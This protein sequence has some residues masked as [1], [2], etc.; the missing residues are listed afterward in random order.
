V[1]IYA[2]LINGNTLVSILKPILDTQILNGSMLLT[3][4]ALLVLIYRN[5]HVTLLS[6]LRII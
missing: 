5:I 2:D 4:Y 1:V 6:F 3:A